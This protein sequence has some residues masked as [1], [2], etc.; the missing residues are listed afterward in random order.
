MGVWQWRGGARI[1]GWLVLAGLAA[2]DNRR[3]GVASLA[4]AEAPPLIELMIELSIVVLMA[5]LL[6][7][8]PGSGS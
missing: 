3:R 1:R 2:A 5:V 8:R 7:L 6:S 4:A